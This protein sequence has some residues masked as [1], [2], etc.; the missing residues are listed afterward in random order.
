MLFK[1]KTCLLGLYAGFIC[2][3]VDS[4]VFLFR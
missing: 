3:A 4:L 2:G 1:R